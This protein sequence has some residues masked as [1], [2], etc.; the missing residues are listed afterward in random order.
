MNNPDNERKT[1]AASSPGTSESSDASLPEKVTRLE[2]EIHGQEERNFPGLKKELQILRKD[3]EDLREGI[4]SKILK[5]V[6][7]TLGIFLGSSGLVI[8]ALVETIFNLFGL[9]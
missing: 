7:W 3:L 1:D 9:W 4:L 5:R 2:Q 8:L 6:T